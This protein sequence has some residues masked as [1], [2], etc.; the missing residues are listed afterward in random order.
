MKLICY[1]TLVTSLFTLNKVFS[2]LQYDISKI[3]MFLIDISF[4]QHLYIYTIFRYLSEKIS[5]FFD[6]TTDARAKT[7]SAILSFDFLSLVFVDSCAPAWTFVLARMYSV[8][9]FSPSEGGSVSIVVNK[10]LTP[11]KTEVF[12]PPTKDTKTFDK[13]LQQ[14][15]SPSE[16]WSTYGIDRVFCETGKLK[17]FKCANY[18][19]V[20]S[21]IVWFIKK[22]LAYMTLNL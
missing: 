2:F 3:P 1:F 13:L 22:W 8:V 15:S 7:A 6:F 20:V 14:C 18:F 17:V 10:W 9:Q 19:C 16:R 11:K 21:S 12:W 4:V 5:I